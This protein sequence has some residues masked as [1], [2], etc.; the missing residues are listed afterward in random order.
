[1]AQLAERSPLKRLVVGSSPTIPLCLKPKRSRCWFVNPV[2]ASLSLVR[3]PKW[4]VPLNGWQ[5]VLKT[6]VGSALGVRFLYS[7]FPPKAEIVTR[8]ADN[9]VVR[10]GSTSSV[11]FP[12]L[13]ELALMLRTSDAVVQFHPE[14]LPLPAGFLQTCLSEGRCTKFDSWVRG[15]KFAC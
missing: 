14:G 12:L 3:H 2:L 6:R 9:C 4:R 1:M 8:T 13:V 15:F 10:R 7:P 11:D 5:L